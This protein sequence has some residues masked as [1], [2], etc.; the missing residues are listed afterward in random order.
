M[1]SVTAAVS[2]DARWSFVITEVVD[3][4]EVLSIGDDPNIDYGLSS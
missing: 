2:D 1:L 4:R 3:I